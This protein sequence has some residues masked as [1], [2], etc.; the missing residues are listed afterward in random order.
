MNGAVAL[1]LDLYELRIT[2]LKTLEDLERFLST[3][4]ILALDA[5]QL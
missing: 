1:P 3:E 4:D 5:R 2:V